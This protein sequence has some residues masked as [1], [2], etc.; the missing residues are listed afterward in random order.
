MKASLVF[1]L[2]DLQQL[3][4]W[5]ESQ[6]RPDQHPCVTFIPLDVEIRR[7]D[8]EWH[9]RVVDAISQFRNKHANF[10]YPTV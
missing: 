4:A 2:K 5:A 6:R 10:F 8:G 1:T 3:T 9:G 7:H